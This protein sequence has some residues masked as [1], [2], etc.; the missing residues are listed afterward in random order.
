L[1]KGGIVSLDI[2]WKNL[3]AAIEEELD[4][5]EELES[6]KNGLLSLIHPSISANNLF[7]GRGIKRDGSKRKSIL[8]VGEN[9]IKDRSKTLDDNITYAGMLCNERKE[10]QADCAVCT[11]QDQTQ[12]EETKQPCDLWQ[13]T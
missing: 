1:T 8:Y 2:N 9:T 6:P 4:E 10:S 7:S 11:T 3:Q 13:M 12:V 5:D